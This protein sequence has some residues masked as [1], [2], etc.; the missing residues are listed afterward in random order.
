MLKIEETKEIL[1]FK[2]QPWQR[3]RK[4]RVAIQKKI[5][6]LGCLCPMDPQW[7]E[8][9]SWLVHRTTYLPETKKVLWDGDGPEC[10]QYREAV[11]AQLEDKAKKL[12][13]TG[14]HL[15]SPWG[16]KFCQ[17]VI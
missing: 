11:H 4:M 5:L 16:G 14:A 13:Y 2:E 3:Y 17:Q 10:E 7:Q 15:E 1:G 12:K 8:L 6:E 9:I